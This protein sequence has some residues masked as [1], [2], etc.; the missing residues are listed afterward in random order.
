MDVQYTKSDEN[1]NT[2]AEMVLAAAISHAVAGWDSANDSPKDLAQRVLRA[3][4]GASKDLGIEVGQII[5]R[6]VR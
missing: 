1:D 2:D 4:Q 3:I 6:V 5:D